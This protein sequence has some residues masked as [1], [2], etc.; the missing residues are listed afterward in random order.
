MSLTSVREERP[1]RVTGKRNL[2]KP[3]EQAIFQLFAYVQV[4]AAERRN[5]KEV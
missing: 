4:V 2:T 1:L 5:T 3:T